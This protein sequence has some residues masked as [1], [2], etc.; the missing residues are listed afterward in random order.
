MAATNEP[1]DPNKL[2]VIAVSWGRRFSGI[3]ASMAAVM[4]EQTKRIGIA[5]MGRHLPESVP[6]IR[7][8]WFVRHCWRDRWRIWHARRNIDML[9][10]LILRHVLRFRLI[11][12]FTS[13]AQRRHSWITRFYYHHMDG[14]IATSSA[15][16]SFLDRP[17][18]V[19]CHGVNTEKFRPPEDRSAAWAERKLPGRCPAPYF[20]APLCMI[21]LDCILQT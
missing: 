1:I 18:V 4:P 3:N 11:L 19:V 6:H 20:S 13:A 14:I 2:R 15:A 16:A 17:A 9:V 21:F 8:G 5:A 7:V 12:V 10:G